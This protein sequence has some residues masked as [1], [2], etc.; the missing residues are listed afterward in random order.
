[1]SQLVGNAGELAARFRCAVEIACLIKDQLSTG[2]QSVRGSLEE[3]QDGFCPRTTYGAAEGGR[4]AQLED[5]AAA[6]SGARVAGGAT[7]ARCSVQ[8]AVRTEDDPCQRLKSI[9]GA[10][11]KTIETVSDPVGSRALQPISRAKVLAAA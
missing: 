8:A 6:I 11:Q 4:R 2:R 3:V 10:S 7:C 5:Q 9:T 1:M